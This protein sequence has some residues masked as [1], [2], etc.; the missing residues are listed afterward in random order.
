M[1]I[2][3]NKI[4]LQVALQSV[5]KFNRGVVGCVGVGANVGVVGCLFR[6]FVVVRAG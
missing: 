6:I 4:L 3:P 1:V 5:Y 2:K